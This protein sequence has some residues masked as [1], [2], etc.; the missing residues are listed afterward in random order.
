MLA[1][2]IMTR[3]PECVRRNDTIEHAAALM[4]DVGVGIIPVVDGG[5]EPR[6]LGVVTDRDI[7]MRHVAEGHGK[8][9]TVEEAM[10]TDG[11]VT[12]RP[13]EDV[14]EVMRRMRKAQVRRVPVVEDGGL[15]VGIVSQ[16]DLAVGGADDR[17]V[18]ETLEAISE[19][20][21]PIR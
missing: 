18:E 15:L 2:E 11:L 1:R 10:T 13:D 4:R 19:P 3:T 20:A 21:R 9:C 14:N 5:E 12:A 16:A 8:G 6:L 7:V 17:E